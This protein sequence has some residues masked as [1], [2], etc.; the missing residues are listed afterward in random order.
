[1]KLKLFL[2]AAFAAL[3][4]L[5]ACGGGSSDT[6]APAVTSPATLSV[7]ETQAGTGA[8]AASGTIPVVKYTLW[9]YNSA[10]ANLKGAQVDTGTINIAGTAYANLITLGA[11]KL[12]AGF[13]QGVTGMKV[14]ARRTLLVPSSLGYGATGAGTSIPPNTGL[15]FEVELVSVSNPVTVSSP[16]TLTWTETLAGSGAV[17]VTGTTPII[18]YTGWLYDATAVNFKGAQFDTGTINATGTA[19]ASLI[20]LGAGSLIPG[21]EQSVLGMKIG[22]KRTM[23][24]PSSLGYGASGSGAVVPPNAGLVFDVELVFI[25]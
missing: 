4:G 6:A 3:L 19:T 14:G 20:K 8:V 16:A 1:M 21:F 9:L 2:I 24:I 25:N 13:E 22:A 17:L 7:T 5:S 18:K 23:W 11:G 10:A 12:I 15:V